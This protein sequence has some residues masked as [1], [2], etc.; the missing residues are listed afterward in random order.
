MPALPVVLKGP[1]G[2]GFPVFGLVDSGADYCV[3]PVDWSS[4]LGIDLGDCE[5]I[6]GQ[7][8]GGP[9]GQHRWKPG[10]EATVMER[11]I[12]VEGF[13]AETALPLLGRE[14]FFSHFKISFDQRKRRFRLEVYGRA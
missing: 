13:F 7:T 8:A 14:D 9:A 1:N 5:P 10:L 11:K 4:A 6:T 3:F 12:H 2:I